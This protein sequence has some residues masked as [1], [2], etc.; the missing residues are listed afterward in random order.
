MIDDLLTLW[1]KQATEAEAKV[2]E[3]ERKTQEAT[4]DEEKS[5]LAG[6][7]IAAI[8]NVGYAHG[9]LDG[10]EFVKKLMETKE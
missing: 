2:A 9:Y 10:A 7:M 1:A 3:L 5:E 4:T 8:L 6:E